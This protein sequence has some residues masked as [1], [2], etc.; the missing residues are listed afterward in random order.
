M[1]GLAAQKVVFPNLIG[2]SFLS[3]EARLQL[4]WTEALE[5]NEAP[6]DFCHRFCA[7]LCDEARGA[8]AEAADDAAAEREWEATR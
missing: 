2:R 1:D 4:D 6:C 3:A 8:N 7:D 5:L